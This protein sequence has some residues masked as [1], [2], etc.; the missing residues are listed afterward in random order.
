MWLVLASKALAMLAKNYLPGRTYRSAVEWINVMN[1]V[2]QPA[3]ADA[4]DSVVASH[5][6]GDITGFFNVV[7]TG[8]YPKNFGGHNTPFIAFPMSQIELVDPTESHCKHFPQL[9]SH[10]QFL[11]SVFE[12]SHDPTFLVQPPNEHRQHTTRFQ[13]PPAAQTALPR[14]SS[15]RATPKCDVMLYNKLYL[16]RSWLET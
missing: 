11:L 10:Y 5:V 6:D 8:S 9:R 13:I 14:P 3:V 2:N 4:R 15:P 16:P 7:E 1:N 12:P